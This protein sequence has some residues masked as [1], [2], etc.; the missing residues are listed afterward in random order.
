MGMKGTGEN[1]MQ[2]TADILYLS[3]LPQIPKGWTSKYL[4]NKYRK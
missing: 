2:V 4:T 3:I 1:A